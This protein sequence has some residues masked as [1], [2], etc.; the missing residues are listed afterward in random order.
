L[1]QEEIMKEEAPIVQ[2][3]QQLFTPIITIEVQD[4]SARPSVE[5]SRVSSGFQNK[6][7]EYIGID[8]GLR[9]NKTMGGS[10]IDSG[11]RDLSPKPDGVMSPE[12]WR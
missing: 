11:I 9:R 7:M 12:S 8:S 2:T 4:T 1:Q 10:G 3:Q 6:T 5:G